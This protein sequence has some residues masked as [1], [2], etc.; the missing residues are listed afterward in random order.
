VIAHPG[1]LEATGGVESAAVAA[2]A[3]LGLPVVVVNP[4]QVRDFA[5]AR[6]RLAKTNA[7]DAL[8]K[9]SDLPPR[10]NWGQPPV[11]YPCACLTPFRFSI[12]SEENPNKHRNRRRL[13]SSSTL[14]ANSASAT[15][16]LR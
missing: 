15:P 7:I 2:L 4:R 8:T 3:K 16:P 9:P 11:S 12:Y 6:G 10:V 5:K 1:R 14:S 13:C